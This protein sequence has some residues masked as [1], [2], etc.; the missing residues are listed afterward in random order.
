[1]EVSFDLLPS[2]TLSIT[3]TILQPLIFSLLLSLPNTF[4]HIE[5]VFLFLSSFAKSVVP[6]S[7]SASVSARVPDSSERFESESAGVL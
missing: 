7:F 5:T 1:M 2:A 6:V 3:P 4:F